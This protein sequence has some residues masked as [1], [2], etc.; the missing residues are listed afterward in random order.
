MIFN[1]LTAML[2]IRSLPLLPQL[3]CKCCSQFS[4]SSKGR[5]LVCVLLPLDYTVSEKKFLVTGEQMAFWKH[6]I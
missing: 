3:C 5:R 1:A 2:D 4:D 6:K